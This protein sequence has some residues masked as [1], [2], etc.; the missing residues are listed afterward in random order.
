MSR[1]EWSNNLDTS[2]EE[3]DLQ[4]RQLVNFF[5]QFMDAQQ[6]RHE[7]RMALENL[8]SYA[9]YHFA[10]EESLMDA[11]GYEFV[12]AHKK[13]HEL[14]D[15]R[16][17]EIYLRFNAGDDVTGRMGNLLIKWH[18]HI[19]NDDTAYSSIVK[20]YEDALLDNH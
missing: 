5:N 1:F 8:R 17:N 10:F 19:L 16:L 4:H 12:R 2:I 7:V 14:I 15:K 20:A 13:V 3:I 9:L 18:D 11:A 6:D